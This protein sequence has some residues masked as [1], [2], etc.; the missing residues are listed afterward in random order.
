MDR[1]DR[2]YRLNQ[3]LSSARYPV[4]RARIEEELECKRETVK[5]TI[6]DMR[7]YLNA[8]IE[9]DR[10][11]NGYYYDL[12]QGEI[13][14][15][16]GLWF[17]ASELHGL[18]S[19]QQLLSEMQ[20][21]LLGEQLAPLR[22]RI[23]RLLK[24]QHAGGDIGSRLRVQRAA[25]RPA[26]EHFGRVADATARRRRL[27]IVY[28][29]RAEDRRS[30]RE[31]SPQRLI[32][33]RDNWYLLAW[34]HLREA[35]RTFAIDAIRSAEVLDAAA[36]E[37]PESDLDAYQQDSYGIF[38]GKAE[39]LA[40]LRFNAHS[41]RWVAGEQ[42]HP[43]QRGEWRDDGGYEL[44]VPFSRPEELIMDILKY[45]ADVE[46]IAPAWLRQRVAGMLEEAAARYRKDTLPPGE[47]A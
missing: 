38:S 29:G 21:G 17:N 12:S 30:E 13:Y 5:R 47:G 26:G 9:Y 27:R 10:D 42:W 14:E 19:V 7:L 18:L 43:Q 24:N 4:P 1:F 36:H 25:A 20:P 34:C 22:E 37:V 33:Y 16:P 15:L 44:Q 45:G 46:V 23:D 3:L 11:K 2:I 39:S 8:P 6:R 35:L 41:A 40:V 31:L 28:H 32:H